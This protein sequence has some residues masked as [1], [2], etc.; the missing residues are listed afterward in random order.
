MDNLMIHLRKACSPAQTPWT[1]S[2]SH[3]LSDSVI[4][5]NYSVKLQTQKKKNSTPD[6]IL[7]NFKNA[8]SHIFICICRA[9]CSG[10][11]TANSRERFYVCA[12][13]WPPLNSL[14]SAQEDITNS[15]VNEIKNQ[16]TLEKSMETKEKAN[17]PKR[18]SM[19]FKNW[20]I[21]CKKKNPGKL[22]TSS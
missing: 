7:I 3:S 14:Q 22:Y 20:N 11:H 10:L 9:A 21:C 12:G 4:N 8:F 13:R 6:L 15:K 19:K 17:E 16:N 1:L 18:K 2:T 5:R